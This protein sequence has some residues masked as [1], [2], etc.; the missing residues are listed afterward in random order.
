MAGTHASPPDP[1]GADSSS[2]SLS[3]S[4]RM[5]FTVGLPVAFAGLAY[6]SPPTAAIAPIIAAPTV[7]AARQLRRLPAHMSG[8]FNAITWTYTASGLL[9]PLIVGLL[10]A[11]ISLGVLKVLFGA[12]AKAYMAQFMKTT[13]QGLPAEAIAQRKIWAS[14]LR[15]FIMLVIF[16]FPLAGGL[17]EA[18]KYLALRL[19]VW[20]AQPKHESEYLIYAIAAGIG[21][22]TF[23]NLLYVYTSIQGGEIATKIAITVLSLIHI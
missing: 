10:Q 9:G 21:F 5:L 13:V 6:A 18:T 4:S 1:N 23:E 16:C 17:E 12:D 15:H 14:D 20:R 11:A 3:L 7:L 2:A 19:A 8:N 22:A